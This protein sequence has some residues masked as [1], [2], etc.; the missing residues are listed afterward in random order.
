IVTGLKAAGIEADDPL[1]RA[2]AGEAR[3]H[4]ARVLLEQQERT[5]LAALDRPMYE[6]PR[7]TDAAEMSG[8]L[9]LAEHLQAAGMV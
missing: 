8:L 7:L 3:D 1:T 4:A 9:D 6:L 2:L 5:V